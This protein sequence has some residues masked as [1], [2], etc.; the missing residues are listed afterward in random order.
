MDVGDWVR[1][2]FKGDGRGQFHEGGIYQV[3]AVDSNEISVAHDDTGRPNGW[4]HRFFELAS[5]PPTS[6]PDDEYREIMAAQ[7]IM[8]G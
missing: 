3:T 5:S 7:E 1:C 4:S 8:E 2:T 6:M